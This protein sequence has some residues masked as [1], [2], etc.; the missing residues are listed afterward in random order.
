M[1]T[2]GCAMPLAPQSTQQ[3]KIRI[4]LIDRNNT[5]LKV[6]SVFLRRYHRI[7]IAG[8]STEDEDASRLIATMNPHIVLIDPGNLHNLEQIRQEC[9]DVRIIV[10]TLFDKHH[11][12]YHRAILEAGADELVSKTNLTTDLIPAICRMMGLAD[13]TS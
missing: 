7:E 12:A 11:N 13:I 8:F 5:F 4:L 3:S 6:V 1:Y 9:P 10:L 2:M